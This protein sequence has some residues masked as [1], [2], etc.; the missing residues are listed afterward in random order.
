MRLLSNPLAGLLVTLLLA[1]C[2]SPSVVKE[3]HRLSAAGQPEAALETL[4]RAMR[5]QPYDGELRAVYFR[6]REIVVANALA[7]AERAHAA[8]RLEEA[9]TQ[10]RK[11]L[12]ADPEQG[13]ASA[14][15]L[16]A[17]A[18]RRRAARLAQAEA[19]LAKGESAGAQ[20]IAR[21]LL[22][23]SPG[24]PGARAVLRAVDELAAGRSQAD[25][26]AVKGPL[27]QPI[28][29][30]FRDVPL[31]NVFEAISRTAGINFVFDK[32]VKSDV[33]VTVFVRDTAIDEVIRL[34]LATNQL[35][36]KQLNRN[37]VLVYP[38]N[39]SKL[40]EYQELV[41]RT[42]YLANTE[43]KQAQALIKQVVK[44]KDVFIDE[45]LNI[46]IIKDTP[47]AVRLAERLVQ[48]LDVPDA[49][50][51]LEVEVLEISRNRLQELGVRFPDQIGYGRLT[52]P[53]STVIRPDGSSTT[54]TGNA[55]VAQGVI[56]LRA[57]G[58]LVP[59]VANPGLLLNLKDQDG[60][61][62]ILANPRIRVRNREKA[63]IHIGDKLP[64][65]TSTSTAN[66]GVSASVN[67][68]DVGLKLDVQPTVHLDDD[69]SMNVS[70]EV[71]SIVKEVLGP[72]NSLAY[73]I[74]T[75]TASTVL[76][77]RN[78]ETQVLA[79][80]ISDD[81]RGSANRL[82]GVGRA[83]L[84]GR[85]FSNE[86]SSANRTEIVLL[87]TPRVVRNLRPPQLAQAALP[88]GTGASV[89]AEPLRIGPTA[90]GGLEVRG[91]SVEPGSGSAPSPVAKPTAQGSPTAA[92]TAASPTAPSPTESAD[93]VTVTLGAPA[94]VLAGQ[95]FDVTVSV[96]AN[97]A[98]RGGEV[99]LNIDGSLFEP[100][101]GNSAAT[102]DV[103]LNP[104]GNTA[105]GQLRLRS[106]GVL[107]EGGIA[108]A[109]GRLA[110]E[111]G[112]ASLPLPAPAV[113]RVGLPK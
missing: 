84:L 105:T 85:L 88:S 16:E 42:F 24:E 98:V 5:E 108:V 50:V 66:V 46:M 102:S 64:V 55:T 71:S 57:R 33:R 80:L 70:L 34:V 111:S 68:L 106:L 76:R 73:Q 63:K 96:R 36:R 21:A 59:F 77:L 48:T 110:L 28:T 75:R 91:A 47:E 82:P 9:E 13:R 101:A 78:G 35:E 29:L 113:V 37:S 87:I 18:S 89:G 38:L 30:E 39:A 65:F 103:R 79:G 20:A 45:K 40:N 99:S 112:E 100:V 104:S 17:Q 95:E 31:R 90:L 11:A 1:A 109:A 15:L 41:T 6:T 67:Y 7:A 81:E 60:D 53:S 51:M 27:A 62:K 94:Q 52:T 74:G 19:L 10:A 23:E 92:P 3:S 83:P 12:Q 49:E 93:G 43:A 54:E 72:Q 8:G 61:S 26:G 32:D 56:D 97:Q 58:G 4:S 2:A 69:V 107:G 86:S 22:A 25:A 44:T 14:L